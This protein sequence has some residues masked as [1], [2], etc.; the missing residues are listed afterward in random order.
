MKQASLFSATALRARWDSNQV[1][2]FLLIGGWNTLFGYLCFFVIYQLA[3]SFLHYLLVSILAH[4]VAVSQSYVTQRYIVFRSNATM[5]AEFLRFNGSHLGVLLLGLLAMFVLVEVIELSPLW[6][7]ALVTAGSVFLSYGLHSRVSFAN[8]DI[9][10]RITSTNWQSDNAATELGESSHAPD[11]L[12]R[13][14]LI[15]LA[16]PVFL[17]LI[18][19]YQPLLGISLA[20]VLAYACWHTLS[21]CVADTLPPSKL[22]VMLTLYAAILWT[23]F[24]GAGHFF[25]AIAHDWIIRDAVLHDLVVGDWPPL[26]D[27][28]DDD[29]YLLRAPVA[30]F[31]PAAALAKIFGIASADRLLWLWTVLGVMLFFLLLPLRH[32]KSLRFIAGLLVI[33]FFSGMDIVGVMFPDF[34]AANSP[35]PGAFIDWWIKPPPL[36]SYWSNTSNLYWN[37]NHCLP[38]WLAIAMFYRHWRHPRFIGIAPLLVALL[39]L[40]S[41]FA[42]IGITP[43]LLLLLIYWLKSPTR[44]QLDIP[45]TLTSVIIFGIIF[46]SLVVPP[47]NVQLTSSTITAPE[48]T[49]W[50]YLNNFNHFL[51]VAENYILFV[52][53]EFGILALLVLRNLDKNLMA[54]ALVTLLCL[55]FMSLGPGNDLAMRGSIPSLTILSIAALH[56]LTA[57]RYDYQL[58]RRLA[59]TAVLGLGAVTS[60]F[61]IS[62]AIQ[63]KQWSPNLDFTLIDANN[64]RVAQHYLVKRGASPFAAV[65]RQSEPIPNAV[66]WVRFCP[67]I[68]PR[69]RANRSYVPFAW[70]N[71][72]NDGDVGRERKRLAGL[73]SAQNTKP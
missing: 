18:G 62:R 47:S 29:L 5:G 28:V 14:A 65:L 51:T 64:G 73:P 11:M 68:H 24:G 32:D 22:I 4:C 23:V 67:P 52:I 49:G 17:Y 58:I 46:V 36:V 15:Y 50:I 61:E 38:A 71:N 48:N 63:W 27:A 2:R 26:Y 69:N 34:Y 60:Y 7:Q 42:L 31:L 39:P 9:E 6:A 8:T 30:Y 3:G 70:R 21:G 37:P 13:L 40:W 54:A 44:A 66:D 45:A 16:L 1:L 10:R 72:R 59:V 57:M 41:P 20:A 12:T 25:Y 19:W 43:F 33:I 56:Q 53:F 35:M 55:P